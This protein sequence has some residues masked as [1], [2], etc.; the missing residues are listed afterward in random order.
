MFNN[1]YILINI[2]QSIN[3]L[4]IIIIIFSSQVRRENKVAM[5]VYAIASI[6]TIANFIYI[7]AYVII[8]RDETLLTIMVV[9]KDFNNVNIN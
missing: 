2:N 9:I 5:F 4:I 6:V 3:Q 8:K 1:S 7:L